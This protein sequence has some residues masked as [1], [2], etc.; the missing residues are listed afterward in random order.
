[1]W[2]TPRLFTE[3]T[4]VVT[5]VTA[6]TQAGPLPLTPEACSF[7][8]G[9]IGEALCLIASDN[10]FLFWRAFKF[11]VFSYKLD[12]ILSSASEKVAYSLNIC[13]RF[14]SYCE[15]ST[16]SQLHVYLPLLLV[17]EFLEGKNVCILKA[18]HSIWQ[19]VNADPMFVDSVII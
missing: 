2:A 6:W 7:S 9:Q 14:Y 3:P 4:K 18:K 15:H 19:I 17:H 16:L 1:M 12:L 10:T 13:I 5:M 11:A 8:A